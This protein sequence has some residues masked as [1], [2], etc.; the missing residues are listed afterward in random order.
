MRNDAPI[1]KRKLSDEVLD[2]LLSLFESG[3]IRPNDT[4]PSERELMERFQVG[5][6]AVREALQ[7]LERL[8]LI[9]I[10]H[11]ERA[12]VLEPTGDGIFDQIDVTARQLFANSAENVEYLKEARQ[13]LE[14]GITKLAVER[15]IPADVRVL[16]KHLDSMRRNKG[17]RSQFLK[18][19]QAFH[20][21]LA[22]M[23]R[24]PILLAALKAVFKWLSR[25]YAELLGVDGLEDLTLQ[26]HE[27]IFDSLAA[28]D[29]EAAAKHVSD[30][31]LRVNDLYPKPPLTE[32]PQ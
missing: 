21:A 22:N 8:G 2:R 17:N 10:R 12:K 4:M 14:A 1:K 6:P 13:L 25:H 7:S 3:E 31:I 23:T 30:H 15:S 11:G 24:N 16:E 29:A 19:D 32:K 27:A 9:M 28:R 20:L 18:S 5:R 26:E